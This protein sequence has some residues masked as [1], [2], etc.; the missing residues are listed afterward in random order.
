MQQRRIHPTPHITLGPLGNIDLPFLRGPPVNATQLTTR[1]GSFLIVHNSEP[2]LKCVS[3]DQILLS[4][5][6]KS[7]SIYEIT[8]HPVPQNTDQTVGAVSNITLPEQTDVS[9]DVS[10]ANTEVNVSSPEPRVSTDE[11]ERVYE[12]LNWRLPSSKGLHT[13]A[14]RT[15]V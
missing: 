7:N 5:G 13:S 14:L 15:T 12:N 11:P 1:L 6:M 3:T 4:I 2:V 9:T 10:R 8:G